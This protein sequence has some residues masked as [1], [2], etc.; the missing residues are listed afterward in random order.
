MRTI[1]YDDEWGI[2]QEWKSMEDYDK[3]LDRRFKLWEKP[4]NYTNIPNEE[5]EDCVFMCIAKK[6]EYET[7][8]TETMSDIWEDIYFSHHDLTAEDLTIGEE[9]GRIFVTMGDIYTFEIARLS[10]LAIAR[11]RM[12]RKVTISIADAKLTI[13]IK[14][15][16]VFPIQ[17]KG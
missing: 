16:S 1:F 7:F 15:K 3:Y 10:P 2:M 9:N 6:G 12:E 17:I 5:D 13:P 14:F 11:M 8:I 4:H